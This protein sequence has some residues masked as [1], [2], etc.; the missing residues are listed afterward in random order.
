M[1]RSKTLKA[2]L[3]REFQ[4]L[5]EL[6]AAVTQRARIWRKTVYIGLHE[7][8]VNVAIKI[9][10]QIQNVDFYT[11][12]LAHFADFGDVRLVIARL[13][14]QLHIAALHLVAR[15]LQ[16]LRAHRAVHAAAHRD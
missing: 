8:L 14:V 15:V 7:G 10:L 6:Y 12:K 2:L 13:C 3:A 9:I 4:K 11:Q 1:P 16:Q 5:A